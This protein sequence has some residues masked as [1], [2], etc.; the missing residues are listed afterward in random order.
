MS[1][2]FS[3]RSIAA[4]L[5]ASTL[6]W[7]YVRSSE[8]ALGK[9]SSWSLFLQFIYFQLP[10][11]SRALSL[12]HALAFIV[13]I[14]GILNYVYKLL[15][16]PQLEINNSIKWD[17]SYSTVIL[18]AVL[19]NFAPAFVHILD[20]IFN[21]NQIILSYQGKSRRVIVLWCLISPL[22]LLLVFEIIAGVTMSE[23]DENSS[24]ESESRN[25]DILPFIS[26]ARFVSLVSFLFAFFLLTILILRAAYVPGFQSIRSP[27]SRT[28]SK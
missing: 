4:I 22:L 21:Q 5:F 14:S 18:R 23:R 8:T 12:I 24:F 15:L 2:S 17:I 16:D 27:R 3:L 6:A 28:G 26:N 9:F 25:Q 1:I 19:V 10:L 20:V 13:A 7:D 11:K